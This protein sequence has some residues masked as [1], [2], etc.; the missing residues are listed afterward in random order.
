VQREVA[1]NTLRRLQVR[2]QRR[3]SDLFILNSFTSSKAL[4]NGAGA[5]EG[6]CGN[7]SAPQ[8]SRNLASEKGRRPATRR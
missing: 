6:P 1:P 7:A 4:D 8:G 3:Y 2:F 5:L